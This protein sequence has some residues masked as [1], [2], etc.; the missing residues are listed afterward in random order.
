MFIFFQID[1][2][3]YFFVALKITEVK[4]KSKCKNIVNSKELV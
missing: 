3:Q 1:R 2:M 4:I